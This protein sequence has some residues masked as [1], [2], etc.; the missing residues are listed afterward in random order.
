VGGVAAGMLGAA[1][2]I[3]SLISYPVLLA[4]GLSPFSA[5]AT[6][7]V[8][9]VT[10]WPGSALGSRQELAGRAPW[11]RHWTPLMLIGGGAGAA[12]L[13]AT[14]SGA[15]K[16]VVPF[17]VLGGSL[18]LIYAPRLARRRAAGR[19]HDRTLGLCLALLGIY[20][21]YFGAG[22]GVM[23]LAL[24][25][26]LVESHV[27]TANALKNMLVGAATVPAG[28]LIAIFAPVHWGAAVALS[29]GILVGSRLGPPLARRI[30]GNALRWAVAALGVSLA[31]WLWL[32]PGG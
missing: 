3:T 2:G 26:T 4:V 8:A 22:S 31:V 28:V 16:R 21:G 20:S 6:N 11:L 7:L 19:R 30:P 12:L 18:A 13:L 24:L 25:L 9:V 32:K 17:L 15:F 1:G 27:A 14:P 29:A 10:Y 5:N 23:T